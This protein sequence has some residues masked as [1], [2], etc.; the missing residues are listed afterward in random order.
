MIKNKDIEKINEAV[1]GTSA[2]RDIFRESVTDKTLLEDFNRAVEADSILK[3]A[4]TLKA[5]PI[6]PET[7][8]KIGIDDAAAGAA[9]TLRRLLKYGAVAGLAI[10]TGITALLYLPDLFDGDKSD[11][12]FTDKMQIEKQVSNSENNTS[13]ISDNSSPADLKN[14]GELGNNSDKIFISRSNSADDI[15]SEYKP[16]NSEIAVNEAGPGIE[17]NRNIGLTSEKVPTTADFADINPRSNFPGGITRNRNT[18]RATFSKQYVYSM[19]NFLENF[20]ITLNY[21]GIGANF[22]NISVSNS[23]SQV[24]DISMSLMYKINDRNS[25]GI[26]AGNDMFFLRYNLTEGRIIKDTKQ[27]LQTVWFGAGYR[28][29]FPKLFTIAESIEAAPYAQANMAYAKIGMYSQ[30]NAGLKLGFDSRSALI[31]GMN[32]G[33]LLYKADDW[34]TSGK[35]G[36]NVGLEF[37]L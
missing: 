20:D 3:S 36:F 5:G 15:T 12:V 34:N 17:K 32:S 10:F 11:E 26:A 23:V 14:T 7:L 18:P 2:D 25:L 37:G 21:Y 1:D 28:Y 31:L 24:R 4:G 9:L 22:P 19:G 13:N 27:E 29:Q 6:R 35:I 8:S 30:L 16:S 33:M